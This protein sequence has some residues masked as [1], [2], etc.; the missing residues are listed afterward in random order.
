[1]KELGMPVSPK[2]DPNETHVSAAPPP[3][4][5]EPAEKKALVTRVIRAIN[6]L[7]G[8]ARLISWMRSP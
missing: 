4:S 1:M 8:R 3:F 5:L 2:A 6:S 7:G